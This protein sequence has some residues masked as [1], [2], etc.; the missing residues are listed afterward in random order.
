MSATAAGPQTGTIKT[1]IPSRLD[2][3]PWSRFHW[4]VVIGLG[5]VWIL[6][7]LEVTLVGSIASRLT[8]QGSGID[9]SSAQIGIAGAAYVG[10]ACVGAL[11]FGQLTDRFGR[12]RLFLITLALYICATVA[13]A[14]AFAPWYFYLV[15]FFTGAGIGG[16]YSAINSA[17]D[18]LIPARIRG[19]VDLIINGSYWIGS[20]AGAAAAL[21]FLD[22]A[23]FAKDFGWRLAFAVGAVLGLTILLVRRNVPESPRWLF[24]HGREEEAERIVDD[25]EQRTAEESGH[26]LPEPEGEITVRQRERIPF[27]QIARTALKLYPRRSLLGLALFIGQAFLYNGVVFNLGGLFT[28]YFDVSSSAVPVFVILYAIGN[29]LGPV[30]L[31]RLFDTVGRKPMIVFAYLGSSAVA[32]VMAVLFIGG[33]L[34][35]WSLEAFIMGSFFLAS[36]GASAAYLTVSEVFPMETRALAIAFFYAVGTAAGGI[37]G[38]LVF[39]HLISSGSRH[40]VAFAFF[41]GIGLM[42][43]GG[44][45]EIFFGVKAEGQQ[46]ESVAKP[47]TAE[48]AEEGT[49]SEEGTEDSLEHREALR[50]RRAAFEERARAAEHRARVAELQISSGNGD[51]AGQVDAEQAL[52]EIA[53]LRAQAMD[54]RAA[55]QV[56]LDDA[57]HAGSEREAE[58]ACE[59]AAAARDRAEA[60]AR[61][62][63]AFTAEH[64][65]EADRLD[66]LARAAEDRARG[67]EQLAMA[68]GAHAEEE[69]AHR[70][71]RELA[72]A[73]AE[74]HEARGAVQ[75]ERATVQEARS[76]H[77]NEAA[78]HHE[79]L[80]RER[81]Q[82]AQAAEHRVRAAEQRA[83]AEELGEEESGSS[84]REQGPEAERA[85]VRRV[86]EKRMRDRLERSRRRRT[87]GLRRF[88]PGP[89]GGSSFYSPG[90]L[91]TSIDSRRASAELD[92]ER[93]VDA[94]TRALDEHGPVDRRE[95]ARLVGA[96][97]WG[98]GRFRQ[99]IRAALDEHRVRQGSGGTLAPAEQ[100][101]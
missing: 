23:I 14:F 55:M 87:Q 33:S 29:F 67:H 92:L 40:E 2:R 1:D 85:R 58:A 88:R 48:E 21:V 7:G 93:E 97:Y 66:A 22:T 84:T 42:T 51:R 9:I 28:T 71:A 20:A 56:E 80:A 94:I 73:K 25:I 10:G 44:I 50:C 49:R 19:R 74:L 38:P 15:R 45:A 53:E 59:R 64:E 24:I 63:S 98:P 13:T 89:G 39:S 31:G 81:E 75:S 43:L 99:A 47:L 35:K 37:T 8:S 101:S 41:I 76:N 3:L 86:L 5:T 68:A 70:A 57:E 26:E 6:D 52:A 79:W 32:T 4:L 46:L 72:R 27:R 34:S 83:A 54:E 36:A 96:R 69:Q 78:A 77:A 62:V 90:M 82:L 12:K 60:L 16:E 17:I 91:G 61:R 95:L 18:E 11:F 65:H 30:L 100:A